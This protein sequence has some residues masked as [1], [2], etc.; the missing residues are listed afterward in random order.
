MNPML[1]IAVLISMSPSRDVCCAIDLD[2]F[3]ISDLVATKKSDGMCVEFTAAYKGKR[4]VLPVFRPMQKLRINLYSK[5]DKQER[6]AFVLLDTE[7]ITRR[8]EQ[9]DVSV[10]LHDVPIDIESIEIEFLGV[11]SNRIRPK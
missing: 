10:F 3:V 4:H 6:M 8:R 5:A 2:H 9:F 7:F 1:I 11:R